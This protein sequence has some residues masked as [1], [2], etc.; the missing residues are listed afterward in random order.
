MMHLKLTPELSDG[1]YCVVLVTP[2]VI[3]GK[4][5]GFS[6]STSSERNLMCAV[7]GKDPNGKLGIAHQVRCFIYLI[8]VLGRLRYI[9]CE[10]F[11][12]PGIHSKF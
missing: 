9:D 3:L 11:D 6:S 1:G 12:Q 4:S 5:C 10:F 7:P 8:P 2:F